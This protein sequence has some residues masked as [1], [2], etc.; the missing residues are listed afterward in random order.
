MLFGEETPPAECSRPVK[1]KSAGA[2]VFWGFRG[3]VGG[4]G[5]RLGCGEVF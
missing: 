2:Q 3:M 1:K 4:G 5:L